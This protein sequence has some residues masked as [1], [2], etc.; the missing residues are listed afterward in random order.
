MVD[1]EFDDF[2]KKINKT[3]G[4][5]SLVRIGD[6]PTSNIETLSTGS[7]LLDKALGGGFAVGR[8]IEIFGGEASGKAQP[9]SE[10][11]LTPKGFVPM[12][13]ITEG[14]FVIS[15]EGRPTEV[16]GIFPQGVKEIY[17]VT[18][19]DGSSTRVCKEHLWEVYDVVSKRKSILSTEAISTARTRYFVPPHGRTE[20]SGKKFSKTLLKK[21][22]SV[23]AEGVMLY[24]GNIKNEIISQDYEL[25]KFMVDYAKS[26]TYVDE[27]DRESFWFPNMDLKQLCSDLYRANGEVVIDRGINLELTI[28]Y[29]PELYERVIVDIKLVGFEQTQCIQVSHS[30]QL[31]ITKD[32]IPT[33]NTTLALTG[34]AEVQKL[35]K[36]VLFMDLEHALNVEYASQL[37]VNVD[38][39]ILSQPSNAEEALNILGESV[40]AGHFSI[41]IVDSVAAMVPKKELEG[42]SGE[43]VMGVHAR[44]M[45]QALR[46]LTGVAAKNKT[47]VIWINQTREKI[48]IVYGSNVTTPGGNALKFYATQRLE[49][50]R[51]AQ[52]KL[53][54]DEVIGH[55]L[56]ITVV[57]NKITSPYKKVITPLMYGKGFNKVQEVLEMAI[58]K[59]IVER[60]GSWVHYKGESL[61]Q[62]LDRTVALLEDNL[63]LF[64]E[65]KNQI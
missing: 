56:R 64:E 16:T 12:G 41:I 52:I 37:G 39:M 19:N 59:G 51:G 27:D 42:E 1:K 17:N 54:E 48:G 11:V 23:I 25:R 26:F 7:I 2:V 14:D 32:F 58:S 4:S 21:M 50:K 13:E 55:D 35:G 31:Y 40:E 28:P 49:V 18:F 8:M 33:H 63:E 34:I 38:D 24:D 5:G 20:M 29:S 53:S 3:Y 22:I 44:L 61:A 15:I 43:S 6:T 46:K 30:Q 36:K 57:K 65:I 60:K 45:S 9:V 62:G 47:T 10:P